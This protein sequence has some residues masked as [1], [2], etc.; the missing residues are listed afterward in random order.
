M[1]VDDDGDLDARI[2]E[3]VTSDH[4]RKRATALLSSGIRRGLH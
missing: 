1:H 3:L 2:M 4:V